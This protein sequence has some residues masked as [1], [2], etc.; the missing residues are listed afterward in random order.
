MFFAATAPAQEQDQ[1]MLDRIMNPKIDRT[2]P[3]GGKAFTAG[4]FNSKEYLGTGSY[5][6]VKSARTK[7]YATREFLGI[8]NPWFGRQVYETDAARGLTRYVLSDKAYASKAV[9][10]KRAAG[11]DREAS[12]NGLA[13]PAADR[14][15]IAR[16]KAQGAISQQYAAPGP[17]SVDDVRQLLNKDRAPAAR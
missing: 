5:G 15:F 7:G 17:L 3:M 13:D 8:K 14:R 11:A 12:Q 4:G 6:G 9:Q 16:G 1:K 2:N 10:T